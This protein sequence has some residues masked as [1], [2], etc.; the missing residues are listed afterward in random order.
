M[1]G[2][3]NKGAESW[4]DRIKEEDP[5]WF[6]RIINE[7]NTA[8]NV[9]R[10]AVNDKYVIQ[11]GT[12]KKQVVVRTYEKSMQKLERYLHDGWLVIFAN[13]LGDGTTEYILEKEVVDE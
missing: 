9:V 4:F 12:K 7:H 6:N 11:I 8:S 10:N 5:E 13:Y 3:K 1:F 2:K